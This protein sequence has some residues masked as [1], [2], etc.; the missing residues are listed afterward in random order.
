LAAFTSVAIL[1]DCINISGKKKHLRFLLIKKEEDKKLVCL[2]SYGDG[3]VFIV[4]DEGGVSA[5]ELTQRHDCF[6]ALL[7]SFPDESCVTL[8]N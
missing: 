2:V 1:S 3:D 4:E 8:G 7:V 5:S 6:F